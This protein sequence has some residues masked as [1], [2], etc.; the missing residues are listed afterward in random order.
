MET[1]ET[2]NQETTVEQPE[3]KTF[4]QDEVNAIIGDRLKRDR[5]KYADYEDLKAKAQKYDEA[6]EASKT[7]LQKANDKINELQA[8]ADKL[9]KDA[10]IRGIREK[11]AAETKVPADLLTG[12]TE[13]IC[14]EQ[15]KR[16]LEFA[17][18]NG[19]PTLNDGGEVQ[20]TPGGKTRD[21]FAE[22]AN[23]V[24]K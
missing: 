18:P 7:E 12:E 2:V 6:E 14:K 23:S 5:E 4:T 3:N 21:Q 11:V 10:E 19:Y 24:L 9:S 17:K 22:W 20:H 15:A 13:E 1:N 16:L 8:K